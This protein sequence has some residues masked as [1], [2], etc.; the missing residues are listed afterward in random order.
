MGGGV[1]HTIT[2]QEAFATG[3]VLDGTQTFLA[4]WAFPAHPFAT[5]GPAVPHPTPHLPRWTLFAHIAVGAGG[6][7][8]T[9]GCL[10]SNAP[11]LFVATI[12]PPPTHHIPQ[13]LRG[14]LPFI[15]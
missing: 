11:R 7:L 15:Y 9:L 5:P 6:T 12:L 8:R 4:I 10:L 2:Q 1:A 13:G 3:L 14:L